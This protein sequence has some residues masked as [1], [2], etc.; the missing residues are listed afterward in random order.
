VKLAAI[1]LGSNACRL[2]IN[3]VLV[4]MNQKPE[5]AKL[6]LV[7]VP[8][9]LGFDVFETG[10]ISDKKIDKLIKTFMCYKYLLEVYEVEHMKAC[11]TSAMRDAQTPQR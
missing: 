5:F 3:D 9:R 4:D 1:D 8:L 11:A 2:L 7:R 6:A 10:K